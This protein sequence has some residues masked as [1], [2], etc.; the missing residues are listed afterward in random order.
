[1]YTIA[2]ETVSEHCKLQTKVLSGTASTLQQ[3]Q[4]HAYLS[5]FPKATDVVDFTLWMQIRVPRR[6]IPET[7]CYEWTNVRVALSRSAYIT[8]YR[9]GRCGFWIHRSNVVQISGLDELM[10]RCDVHIH[11]WNGNQDHVYGPQAILWPLCVV[12]N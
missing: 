2:T 5:L 1:M 7:A 4:I 3:H 12:F 10:G 11:Y 6:L 8:D 9:H